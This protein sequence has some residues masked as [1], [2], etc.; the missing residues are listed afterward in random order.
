VRR[1]RQDEARGCRRRRRSR[2]RGRQCRFAGGSKQLSASLNGYSEVPA[3]STAAAGTFQARVA[4]S[5]DEIAYRLSYSALEAAPTQAHIHFG[6]RT[7]S[8][9]VSVWLCGNIPTTPAGVQ[10][11]PPAPATIDGTIKA[12]DVVGPVAQGIAPGEFDELMRAVRAGLTYANVHS[13]KFAPGEIR[14]QIRAGWGHDN[15]R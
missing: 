9:G 10:A 5:G 13:V 12:A 6:Q 3:I 2:G 1:E 11:C 8:G 15:G 14:G 7:T 4:G